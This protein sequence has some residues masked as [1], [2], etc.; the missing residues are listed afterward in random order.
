MNGLWWLLKARYKREKVEA[1]NSE[2]LYLLVKMHYDGVKA[3][4]Q[5]IDDIWNGKRT[6]KPDKEIIPNL[7]KKLVK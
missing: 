2:L 1:Y 5:F 7:L 6:Q 3:P 4:N